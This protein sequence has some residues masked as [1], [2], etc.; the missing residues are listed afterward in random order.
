[1]ENFN[2]S[3]TIKT[4]LNKNPTRCNSYS[5]FPPTEVAVAV[6]IL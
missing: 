4:I 5:Y 6:P 1:M 2:T 3:Q